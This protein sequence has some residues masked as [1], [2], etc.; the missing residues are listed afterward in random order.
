MVTTHPAIMSVTAKPINTAVVGV[1]L[2][3]TVFHFPLLV[4]LHEL[5]NITV[6]VERNAQ[7]EGG[8]ARKFGIKPKIV[9][10]IEEALADPNV[11]FVRCDFPL[12]SE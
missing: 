2:A 9:P 1:G 8:K 4:A 3:G 5:F 10:T 12:R 7:E 6:V 11:E